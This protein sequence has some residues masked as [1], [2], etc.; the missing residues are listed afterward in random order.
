[1]DN[2]APYVIMGKILPLSEPMQFT[3]MLFKGQL[4]ATVSLM[5]LY[6]FLCPFIFLDIYIY[7]YI[8]LFIVHK[9]RKIAV[10]QPEKQ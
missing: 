2:A 7:I 6:F 8:F 3:P 4:Y 9:Q 5:N 1:M 10:V